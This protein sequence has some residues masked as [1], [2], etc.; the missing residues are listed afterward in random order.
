MPY[1]LSTEELREHWATCDL[2]PYDY[3]YDEKKAESEQEFD[4]WLAE[5]N[6]QVAEKAWGEGQQAESEA[7]F[8]DEGY[9]NVQHPQNPYRPTTEQS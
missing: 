8:L 9:G 4:A 5:N 2:D 6:R 3:R 7:Q 1:I